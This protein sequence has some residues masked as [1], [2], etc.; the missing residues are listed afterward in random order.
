MHVDEDNELVITEK[1]MC[2]KCG[3]CY[4]CCELQNLMYKLTEK[5]GVGYDVTVNYCNDY[6]NYGGR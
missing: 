5:C 3:R 2:N 6:V 1:D 4:Y